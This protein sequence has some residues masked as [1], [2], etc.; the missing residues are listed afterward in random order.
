M[1]KLKHL[2]YLLILET[3]IVAPLQAQ[4][5][6]IL[7]SVDHFGI[8]LESYY[9][10]N[11]FEKDGTYSFSLEGYKHG[12][13]LTGTKTIGEYLYLHT[14]LK[15]SFG[16]ISFKDSSSKEESL[17]ET[18]YEARLLVGIEFVKDKNLLSP[19]IGIGYRTLYNDFQNI[20]GTHH[21][22]KYT[23]IPVGVTHRFALNPTACISTSLEYDYFI[24]GELKN[25]NATYKQND[26]FGFRIKNAYQKRELSIGLFFL[27]TDIAK[28]D[29]Q[30][31][32]TSSATYTNWIKKNNT[33]EFGFEIKYF[34]N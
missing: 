16:N 25:D 8:G 30:T 29:T 34:F 20:D 10:N 4:E 22:G 21:E 26:S 9:Y 3:L 13:S 32:T 17:P 12:I 6:S 18:M 2:L 33:K 15:Y 23:Y 27:Y 19:F 11:S 14:D 24:K 1:K 7:K 28:S 31:Y 5:K